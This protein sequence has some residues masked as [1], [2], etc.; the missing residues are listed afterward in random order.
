MLPIFNISLIGIM[1]LGGMNY[2]LIG[3]LC[4]DTEKIDTSVFD[5]FGSLS[6]LESRANRRV[7][8]KQTSMNYET[9][10]TSDIHNFTSGI[11]YELKAFFVVKTCS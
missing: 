8:K 1:A 7:Q 10:C 4:C 9:Q 5:I 2:E 3:S 11:V 6:S